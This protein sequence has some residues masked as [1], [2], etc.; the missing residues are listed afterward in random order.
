MKKFIAE[1]PIKKTTLHPVD[2]A[3][4][5]HLEFVNIHPFVDGNGRCARLLTNLALMSEAYPIIIIPPILRKDYLE[6]IIASQ[7]KGDKEPFYNFM[8]EVVVESLKDYK[9]LLRL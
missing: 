3:S 4:W 2:F 1:I 5:L 9:R 6:T 7:H 8:A